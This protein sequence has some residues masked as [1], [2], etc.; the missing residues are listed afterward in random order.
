[1]SPAPVRLFALHVSPW[2][3]RARWA[4]EHHRIVHER[5]H[6]AP[7][8]G[9]RRL[10]QVVGPGKKRATVPVLIAGDE[11]LTESWDIALYADRVGEGS[12][13]IPAGREAEV[14]EWN[15]L[16]DRTMA[17]GRPLITRS[18]LA[19]PDALDEALPPNVPR[20]ARPLLRP[21][22]RYGMR[23]FARKYGLDLE[24]TA[25][26]IAVMRAAF[27]RA[28]QALSKET[29]YL[30]GSFSYADIVMATCLQGVSPVADR[31]LRLGPATRKAWT[32]EELASEIPDLVA[33]RDKLYEMH[34]KA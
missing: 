7:F 11:V 22:G 21:V 8:L 17:A 5:V 13:L 15:D 19:S 34:R 10:R 33:W 32:H 18:L 30:L 23:W 28:R 16:A 1:M 4:L 29:P 9:E 14:R 3:E 25:A 26:P 27:E 20:W 31:Y 24:D 2:S 12:A 6:H